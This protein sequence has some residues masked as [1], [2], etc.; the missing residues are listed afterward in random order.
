L[1]K[2]EALFDYLKA[3]RLHTDVDRE[4]IHLVSGLSE[5]IEHQEL[6][7][8]QKALTLMGR[9]ADPRFYQILLE[10][11][12]QA[13]TRNVAIAALG[14]AGFEDAKQHLTPFLADGS[15][16]TRFQSALALKKLG[17]KPVVLADQI[18]LAVAAHDW[19]DL[20]QFGNE[21]VPALLNVI[22]NDN[23][24]TVVD[25]LDALGKIGDESI[26][27]PLTE[28]LE[29]SVSGQQHWST[30]H[31][32]NAILRILKRFDTDEAHQALQRWYRQ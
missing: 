31:I 18:A 1:D 22:R 20:V 32:Q 3:T 5:A 21:A 4:D 16:S 9:V 19:S 11:L 6:S 26:V 12:K 23:G 28:K 24:I 13:E 29:A 30:E 14:T 2:A 27:P 25:A 7:V 15:L 8:R 10:A 17:W